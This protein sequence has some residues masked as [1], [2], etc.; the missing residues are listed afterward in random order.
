[1]NNQNN[2]LQV[3]NQQQSVAPSRSGL[4][5]FDPEA[6]AA[7]QKVAGTFIQSGLVPDQF[8]PS[9]KVTKEQAVANT[10]IALDMAAR[11]NVAPLTIMQNLYVVSGKPAFSAKFLIAMVN[12]GGRFEPLRFTLYKT[13]DVAVLGGKQVQNCGCY[14]WTYEKGAEHVEENKLIGTPVT[15]VMAQQEHWG[16][17]WETEL[18]SQMLRYRAASFWI[19]L[20]APE[21][22]MGIYSKE[23]LEDGIINEPIETDFTEVDENGNEPAAPAAAPANSTVARAE[24]FRKA[25][26][27][28]E[29]RAAQSA[30]T[31][32]IPS[33]IA[34]NG[35]A[36]AAPASEASA[37]DNQETLN[38]QA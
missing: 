15:F 1:M 3:A 33:T 27:Q 26:K 14:A 25:A 22:G 9:A 10:L 32:A 35:S 21:L 30:A 23:D 37:S 13:D 24:A 28:A 12:Q 19:S 38:L 18:R 20:Y 7:A 17:K 16:P 29:Q 8:R 31:T 4:N 36:T 5:Y 34:V 6:L 2:S 11:M